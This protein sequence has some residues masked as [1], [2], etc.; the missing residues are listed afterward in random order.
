MILSHFN[1][2]RYNYNLLLITCLSLY[3][4]DGDT[5]LRL[6]A[7]H[8]NV[9]LMRVIL[10]HTVQINVQNKVN[11]IKTTS[12]LKPSLIQDIFA[13]ISYSVKYCNKVIYLLTLFFL[14]SL[15]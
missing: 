3:S 9:D 7:S 1:V 14:S 5:A 11:I 10:D 15:K 8:N 13:L 2:V 6:A 4:Q 12:I